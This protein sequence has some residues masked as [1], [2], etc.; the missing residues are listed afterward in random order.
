MV[1]HGTLAFS[2]RPTP[3]NATLGTR[4]YEVA[5]GID[6]ELAGCLCVVSAFQQ[7]NSSL[8]GLHDVPEPVLWRRRSFTRSPQL[9]NRLAL[10]LSVSGITWARQ[11]VNASNADVLMSKAIN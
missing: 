3:D 7:I 1:M 6:P 11:P 2:G 8:D 9:I 10:H 5:N 4:R